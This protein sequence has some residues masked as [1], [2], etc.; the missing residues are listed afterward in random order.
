MITRQ[1][2]LDFAMQLPGTT[3]D[4]PF[5]GDGDSTVLRHS[6]TRKWFGLLFKAPCRRVG[7]DS[8]GQTDILNLKTD[9]RFRF[10]LESAYRCVLPA[11]HMNKDHWISIV[12]DGD[13]P[14]E[15]LHRLI[16]LSYELTSTHKVS[17]KPSTKRR[18]H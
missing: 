13:M 11:Y 6:D 14:L 10:T 7:L 5:E 12:L 1:Q 3:V 4:T 18:T 17:N 8:D 16:G 9:P 2:I 15:E